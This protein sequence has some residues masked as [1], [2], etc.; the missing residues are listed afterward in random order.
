MFTSPFTFVADRRRWILRTALAIGISM[1]L[2][3]CGGGGG[4]GGNDQWV[5]SWAASP[6]SVS[7]SKTFANQTVRQLM[8]VSAGGDQIRVR[9]SNVFGTSPLVIDS[10]RVARSSSNTSVDVSTDRPAKFSGQERLSLAAGQEI[11]SDP[12]D[13]AVAAHGTVAVSAYVSAATPLTTGHSLGR[14]NNFVGA[15]NVA[16]AASFTPTETNQFY[17]WVTGLDVS[18]A[19][20][21]KVIVAFGDSITDGFN[22]TVGQNNR[23]P[24]YLSRILRGG[25]D[26]N[27]YSVVNAGISGDRWIFGANDFPPGS[28]RFS[29][30]V[31]AQSGITHAVFMLGINDIGGPSLSNTPAEVVTADQIFANIVTA[32]DAAKA[33]GIKVFV[34]TLSPMKVAAF[35]NYYS[36]AGESKRQAV[37]AMI[38]QST[39]FDGIIDF[40]LALR[41]PSDASILRAA[42]DSADHLH[43][44]DAGYEAMAKAAAAVLLK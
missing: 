19:S 42:F 17:A 16:S 26:G 6:Q 38:R 35:G 36:D 2:A 23:Y 37:N 25:S 10:L 4:D 13:L 21:Q 3:A 28:T 32:A 24:N 8:Y 1:S 43:P 31:L 33:R 7:T 20:V 29:R 18:S 11:W 34:G 5:A 22:S 9:V 39:K 30:D 27:F 15:G 14:Q 41:D 12:I 44:S 40:D